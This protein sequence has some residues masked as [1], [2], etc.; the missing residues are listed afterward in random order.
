MYY[1]IVM[2]PRDTAGMAKFVDSDQTA[3]KEQPDLG[4]LCLLK[5]TCPSI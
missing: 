1:N 5:P 4:L 2:Q 3:S